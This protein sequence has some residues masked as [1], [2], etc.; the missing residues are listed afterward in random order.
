MHLRRC[1]Y[2]KQQ[3]G[4]SALGLMVILAILALGASVAVPLLLNPPKLSR[5][6]QT[7]KRLKALKEAIVGKPDV[8]PGRYRHSFGF[9]GD[10]GILPATLDDLFNQGAYPAHSAGPVNHVSFG[11][12]GPYLQTAISKDPDGNDIPAALLDA[13]GTPFQYNG[14]AISRTLVSAGP[15]KDDLTTDDNLSLTISE[16]EWRTPVSGY[17]LDKHRAHI[18]ET[19]LTIYHPDG[20]A[21]LA[22]TVVSPANPQFYNTA[23][24]PVV[25]ETKIPIGLRFFQAQDIESVKLVAINGGPMMTADLIGK[26]LAEDAILFQNSFSDPADLGPASGTTPLRTIRGTWTISGGSITST[27]GHVAFGQMG[28]RDYRLEA[29]VTLNTGAYGYGIYYRSDD[30]TTQTGYL[31]QFDPGLY[32]P[33]GGGLE[34]VIRRVYL[35]NENYFPANRRF[36]ARVR[37]SNAQFAALFGGQIWNESHHVSITVS[38]ER[39]IIKL[40]GVPV[41]DTTDTEPIFPCGGLCGMAGFKIWNGSALFH[42]V[43]VTAIPPFPNE[44]KVWWSFEEGSGSRFYG[45]GFLIDGPEQNG[46]QANATR[47]AIGGIYG[48]SMRLA[49]ANP[50]QYMTVPDHDDLDLGAQGSISLW[51]YPETTNQRSGGLIHKGRL[52]DLS[53]L[54]YSLE[55]QAN[56]RLQLILANVSGTRY[57]LG[58]DKMFGSSDQNRWHHIVAVWDNTG[59]AIYI[60]GVLG[61]NDQ[62]ETAV[63]VRNTSGPLIIGAQ[64]DSEAH[65]NWLNY[66]F[67]G[68]ID[69]VH[70]YKKR[71]TS[72]Q[73]MLLYNKERGP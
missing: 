2:L 17:F 43:R 54:A 45:S 20:T 15:D 31:F 63:A 33:F 37:Y 9:V 53:D 23:T 27:W 28:W 71:L 72:A 38:G 29:D 11:W 40:D 46:I 13:W 67:K 60:N 56:D 14:D 69:E 21:A 62:N 30:S 6:Q 1:S 36:L 12:H 16:D 22:S 39:H 48:A 52:E 50:M 32:G 19:K 41:I 8:Q 58:S 49:T 7:L 18:N 44:E 64:F 70:L 66:P 35:G 42:H 55:F 25:G 34:L 73:I 3:R 24:D 10:L 26:E 51:I 57:T 5:E 61:L 47:L 68:R 4:V 59:M 65:K